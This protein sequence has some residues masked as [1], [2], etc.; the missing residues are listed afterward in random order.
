MKIGI[1]R[2]I[3]KHDPAGLLRISLVYLAS[4]IAVFGLRYLQ[5]V[6]TQGLGQKIMFDLRRRLFSHVQGLSVTYFERNPV[7]R[8]MTRLTGDVEVLNDL[9]T[10]GL[11]SIFG[12]VVILAGIMTV[13]LLLD[14]RLALVCFLVLPPLIWATFIFRARVG[15]SYTTIRVKVAAMNAFLQEN[16][17]GIAV[18]QLF[19][20]EEARASEFGK[21]NREHR[22]AFLRS[23]QAYSVYF[24]TVELL[25]VGAAAL[26]LGYGGERVLTQTLSLGAL[27]AFFQYS[28]RFFRPIRDLSERYNT[29]Q[30][31]MASSERIFELLDTAP[32]IRSA[33]QAVRPEQTRGD[34]RL[35]TCPIRLQGR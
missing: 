31:A 30:G 25:E 22:D 12:D 21:L 19:R 15:E 14:W 1:D 24:P 6:T 11:V 4:L 20:R 9:F 35:R 17:T 16:L 28:E 13:M 3:Q 5:T 27:V 34:I 29:L 2:Y 7:G 26:I 32:E 18:V 33:P 8:V 10:S 23:V